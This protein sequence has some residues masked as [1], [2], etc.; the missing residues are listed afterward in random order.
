M[1]NRIDNI[2]LGVL[3]LLAVALGAS[4]WFNT[5]F[6][7]DIFSA[8]HWQYLGYM[9]AHQTPV[10]TSFYISVAVVAISMLG[11][12]YVL[13]WPRLRRLR[14]MRR[15]TSAPATTTNA[16]NVPAT[17]T[18]VPAVA[19]TPRPTGPVMQRPPRP[20]NAMS[21]AAIAAANAAQPSAPRPDDTRQ[22]WAQMHEIFESAGYTVKNNPKIAGVQT[23]LVAIGLKEVLWIGAIGVSADELR[24]AITKMQNVFSDTL[25][26]IDINVNGFVLNATGDQATADDILTFDT[27]DQLRDYIAMH[28]NPPT[29]PDEAENFDA[30]SA[31]ITT[32][33]EYIG[34]I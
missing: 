2:L 28:P 8:A 30:Y 31:Y 18:S 29:P 17:T 22:Q 34:K 21:A 9:Q 19:G 14:R 13:A 7:F 4:F 3:W 16:T 10:R 33:L 5:K 27:M 20:N 24:G 1:K 15:T 23:A 26:D 6:G 32:V 12:L 11:G 25:E